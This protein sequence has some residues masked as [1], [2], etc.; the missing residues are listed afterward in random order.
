METQKM[1]IDIWQQ[2]SCSVEQ[3]SVT[4]PT[5]LTSVAMRLSPNIR[6]SVALVAAYN[7]LFF[8]DVSLGT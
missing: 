3:R 6:L 5:W 8:T 1:K 2:Q 7:I 4:L